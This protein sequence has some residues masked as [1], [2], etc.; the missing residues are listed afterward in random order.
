VGVAWGTWWCLVDEKRRQ[1][2]QAGAQ[3]SLQS[4]EK[5]KSELLKQ[6]QVRQNVVHHSQRLLL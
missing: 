2:S 6:M 4:L 5:E 1:A 3:A